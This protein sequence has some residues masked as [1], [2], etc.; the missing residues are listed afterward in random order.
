MV[1]LIAVVAVLFVLWAVARFHLSGAD[2]SAF[3]SPKDPPS[4]DAQGAA[5]RPTPC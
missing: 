2:V 3:D 1:W 4:A 5:R